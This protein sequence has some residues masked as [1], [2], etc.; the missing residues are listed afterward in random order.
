MPSH[1]PG[2]ADL[3]V[4]PAGNRPGRHDP[5]SFLAALAVAGLD[6]AAL[7][8]HDRIDIAAELAAR[9]ADA[10]LALVVGEEIT[11]RDGHLLGIGLRSPVAPGHSLGDSV[12]A[13]HDQ[14]GLAIVAHPLLPLPTSARSRLLAALAD[15][16]PERRPDALEGFNPAVAW[17]PLHRHRIAALAA[18]A[19]YAVVG[20]SDAHRPSA[21]GR[22]VTRF[23]GLT[24]ADLRA[25]IDA[26]STV[27]DGRPYGLRDLRR[28][29]AGRMAGGTSRR[30]GR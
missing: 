25:A 4:H 11:T 26:R 16:S 6:L 3:H 10:G 2:R 14:G 8:D 24:L 22:G 13:V 29:V 27:V 1:V 9:A 17:L 12:A 23:P 30:A 28:I 19:G 7:T 20:G 18:S 5:I 21:V 15:G